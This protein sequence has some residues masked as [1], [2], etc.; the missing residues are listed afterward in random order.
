M[1]QREK[2]P[3]KQYDKIKRAVEEVA[4]TVSGEY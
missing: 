4:M 2:L 1:R 3:Q